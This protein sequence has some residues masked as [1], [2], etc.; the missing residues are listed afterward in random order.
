MTKY[1]IGENEKFKTCSK[2]NKTN[3]LTS[4]EGYYL[5]YDGLI[6]NAYLVI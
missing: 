6:K 4:N 1:I 2:W 5:P 3:C